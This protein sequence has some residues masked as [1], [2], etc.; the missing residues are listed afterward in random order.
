[1]TKSWDDNVTLEDFQV[2]TPLERESFL[3]H[4]LNID[5]TA[6]AEAVAEFEL[7][8][9][10]RPNAVFIST[11]SLLRVAPIVMKRIQLNRLRLGVIPWET[12][13]ADLFSV[14]IVDPWQY[15]HIFFD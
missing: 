11:D 1:M 6:I 8:H 7:K 5:K 12:P 9:N 14:G 13:R 2:M 3:Y 15:E 4:R 10:R